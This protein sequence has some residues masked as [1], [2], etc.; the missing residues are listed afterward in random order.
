MLEKE[1]SNKYGLTLK[2]LI[3]GIALNVIFT[4]LLTPIFLDTASLGNIGVSNYVLNGG[5]HGGFEYAFFLGSIGMSTIT[6]LAIALINKVRP[7]FSL[8]ESVVIFLMVWIGTFFA[9]SP[10]VNLYKGWEN[11][12][13]TLLGF[14]SNG[15]ETQAYYAEM[16]TSWMVHPEV[17][18]NA[19]LP[20]NFNIPWGTFTPLI[21]WSIVFTVSAGLFFGFIAMLLRHIY[22]DIEDLPFP[23]VDVAEEL[24]GLVDSS[25]S[26]VSKKSSLFTNKLFWAAFLIQFLWQH[27]LTLAVNANPLDYSA[28]AGNVKNV[29]SFW[30]QW[31][32]GPSWSVGIFSVV[33]F[34]IFLV[35]YAI[36]WTYMMS[37]DSLVGVIIGTI[38]SWFFLPMAQVIVGARPSLD[39]GTPLWPVNSEYSLF[40]SPI[41]MRPGMIFGILLALGVIPIWMHRHEFATIVR[42]IAKEPKADFDPEKPFSYRLVWLGLII[43][44]AIYV[45]SGVAYG[46]PILPWAGALIIISFALVGMM[47]YVLGTGGYFGVGTWVWYLSWPATITGVLFMWL[48][49]LNLGDLNVNNSQAELIIYNGL[50]WGAPILMSV[51]AGTFAFYGAKLASKTQTRIRDS[52]IGVIIALAVA[53][54]VT[55]ITAVVIVNYMPHPSDPPITLAGAWSTSPFGNM[56]LTW[57][58]LFYPERHRLTW[59]MGYQES[60][61]PQDT[62]IMVVVGILLVALFT[63]LKT[64]KPAL[65]LG[66]MGL[67]LGVVFGY[68]IWVPCVV[69]LIAKYLTIKTGGTELFNDKGKPIAVGFI[70]GFAVSM[71][72]SFLTVGIGYY[73]LLASQ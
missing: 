47:R 36:G 53:I 21:S 13:L 12:F 44:F 60:I 63:F 1:K 57:R 51:V 70:A 73:G 52:F 5:D 16:M 54:T 67:A 41:V 22:I 26:D 46:L 61:D 33:P 18:Q 24:V 28:W 55:A 71:A 66:S 64:K 37:I 59:N 17:Y 39:T 50:T 43:S 69:A 8:H 20:R 56:Y 23:A 49:G 6:I 30:P 68:G 27:G 2:S 3:V 25:G 34:V 32:M 10:S 62:I 7:T 9:T 11:P 29:S 72:I 19:L 15:A 14:G 31:D 58:N 65:P 42:G 40:Q 38:I 4:V 35:P 48:F 45:A